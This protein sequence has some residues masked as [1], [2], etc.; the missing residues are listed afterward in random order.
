MAGMIDEQTEAEAPHPDSEEG[1]ESP[2]QER[3]QAGIGSRTKA[4]DAIPA[5]LKPEYERLVMAAAKILYSEQA[6]DLVMQQMSRQVPPA[7]MIGEGAAGLMGMVLRA[8]KGQVSAPSVVAAAIEVAA[9]VADFVSEAGKPV[10]EDDR[11][12]AMQFAAATVMQGIG[13][14]KDQVQNALMGQTQQASPA[15]QSE[16]PME[17]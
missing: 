12:G 15:G 9:E 13:M 2:E 10:S 11:K 8:A 16:Q 1:A 6:K 14:Q 5:E 17:A 7:Q 4:A 3:A